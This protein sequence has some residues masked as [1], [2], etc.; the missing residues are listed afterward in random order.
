[1]TMGRMNNMKKEVVFASL[2]AGL[3]VLSTIPAFAWETKKLEDG[4]IMKY[5]SEET[6][7]ENSGYYDVYYYKWEQQEDRTWK[8]QKIRDYWMPT[9]NHSF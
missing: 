8:L 1:M 9:C 5:A 6:L 3:T 7:N 2:L 4:W